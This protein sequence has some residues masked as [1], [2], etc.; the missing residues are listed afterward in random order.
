[1]VASVPAN[2]SNSRSA[3]LGLAALFD[4]RELYKLLLNIDR[5]D[6][7]GDRVSYVIPQ[8]CGSARRWCWTF[9]HAPDLYNL[10][11]VVSV[12]V[13]VWQSYGH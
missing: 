13:Q 11:A 10:L 3:K 4:N 7:G 6:T 2:A 1:M 9:A 12:D 5:F 8:I